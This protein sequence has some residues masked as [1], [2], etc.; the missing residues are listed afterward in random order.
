METPTLALS[1]TGLEV[2]HLVDSLHNGATTPDKEAE[3]AELR[4]LIVN[5]A[6][7]YRELVSVEGIKP[8]PLVVKVTQAQCW[9]M[10]SRVRTGD[11]G[12]DGTTNIGIPLGLKLYDLMLRFDDGLEEGLDD[13]DVGGEGEDDPFSAEQGELLKAKR[14]TEEMNRNATRRNYK[15]RPHTDPGT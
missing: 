12:I 5:L 15:P 1:L 10:R 13:F 3:L 2:V 8:G 9:L 14:M 4:P 11:I 7:L 6:K